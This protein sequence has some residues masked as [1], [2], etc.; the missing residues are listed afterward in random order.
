MLWLVLFE[1]PDELEDNPARSEE[2]LLRT[3]FL[4]VEIYFPEAAQDS[5]PNLDDLLEV[6]E[7]FRY[8]QS[9]FPNHAEEKGYK[10]LLDCVPL[11]PRTAHSNRQRRMA[12]VS[13]SVGR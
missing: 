9:P 11:I 13:D 6:N 1:C 7:L 4:L 2:D 3:G 8:W 5:R 12:S 10:R